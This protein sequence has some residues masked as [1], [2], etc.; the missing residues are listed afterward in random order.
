DNRTVGDAQACKVS[1]FRQGI[2]KISI[3][4]WC[5]SW[6]GPSVITSGR[7][8]CLGP[9]DL[10]VGTIES[11][12]DTLT[13][14]NHLNKNSFA[15]DREGSVS[16]AEVGDTPEA[17]WSA[18]WP[19]FQQPG[20]FGYSRSVRTSPLRPVRHRRGLRG[21]CS[22]ESENNSEEWHNTLHQV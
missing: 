18:S 20:F 19:L 7:T 15:P 5:S 3:D 2:E 12:D 9:H 17:S 10:A 8:E 6:S 1:V 4:H 21:N 22:A 11:S 16:G 13:P 14:Y